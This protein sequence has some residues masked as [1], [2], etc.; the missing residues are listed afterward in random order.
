MPLP[1]ATA[2][3]QM[4]PVRE[5]WVH[6]PRLVEKISR[7]MRGPVTLVSA[8]AGYGKT[9]LLGDWKKTVEEPERG[10]VWLTL[11]D[12]DNDLSQFFLYLIGAL[13]RRDERIGK[14]ALAMLQSPEPLPIRNTI[15]VLLNE[16]AAFPQ[17]AALVLDDYHAVHQAAVH[18]AMA[19]LLDHLPANLSIA[20][21][22]RM[23]PPWPLDRWRARG[24]LV[25]IRS[26]DLQ[27][28][29]EETV[30]FLSRSFDLRL[31]PEDLALLEKHTEGWPAG[32]Q[33]AAAAIRTMLERPAGAPDVSGFLREFGGGHRHV[34]DYLTHEVFRQ[35]SEDIQ[36]FLMDTSILE[37]FSAPLCDAVRGRDD[38]RGILDYL[39]RANLFLERMDPDGRWFRYHSLCAEALRMRLE[40]MHPESLAGLH[41]RASEWF[42][43]N[44][45]PAEAIGYAAYAGD[46]SRL[47]E[48][49]EPLA[50]PMALRGESGRLLAWLEKIPSQELERHQDLMVAGA[51]ARTA[52]GSPIEDNPYLIAL[53][54]REAGSAALHG[55]ISAMRAIVASVRQDVPAIRENA[56]WALRGLPS[57]DSAIRSVVAIALGTAAMLSGDV[58]SSAA[59]LTL[60]MQEGRRSDQPILNLLAVTLLAQTME[61]LGDMD[62][63]ARWHQY[64]IDLEKDPVLG[65]LPLVGAGYVG[66]G[67]V[68]HERLEYETAEALLRKGIELGRRWESPD[69]AIGGVFSL[70]RLRFTQGDPVDCLAFLDQVEREF[71]DSLPK[72]ESMH[73]QTVRLQVWLAR[74]ET[75]CAQDWLRAVESEKEKPAPYM[76]DIMTLGRARANLSL[77]RPGRALELLDRLESDARSHRRNASLV[78]IDLLRGIAL[79]AQNRAKAA[80]RAV[81]EALSLAEPQRMRRAFLDDGNCRPL[82]EAFLTRH[83]RNAFAAELVEHQRQREIRLHG[84]GSPL[85]ERETDVLRLMAAGLSNQE[86]ADRLVIALSTV[87]THA[88]N[89]FMKLEADNRTQAV[90]RAREKKLL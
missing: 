15:S 10:L 77:G 11:D 53:A 81:D 54:P 2:K 25:E 9:T 74:G 58:E 22:T 85:S 56:E 82:L 13:Q 57:D 44:G 79:R 36:G 86:I 60:A 33:L 38:S 90:A 18:E 6:R 3:F 80:E 31:P 20:I 34:A 29:H 84:G 89:I 65:R 12:D 78:E 47:T 1:L 41:R 66:L 19:F 17:P 75:G 26:E 76:D 32:V 73:L 64:I 69:I 63:A 59:S 43:A 46:S 24:R 70:A 83:P 68:M 42:A 27:F 50:R 48:L 61:R 62:Q 52:Q 16:A 55:E 72:M 49:L 40:Q 30:A 35:Q 39:E 23:D 4:P 87:K 37:R 14:S 28:T 51:W 7:G 67:G 8:P 5:G 71:G 45:F 88:K 21:L